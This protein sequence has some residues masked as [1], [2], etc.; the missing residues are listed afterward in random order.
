MKHERWARKCIQG[1]GGEPERKYHLETLDV[2]G[3]EILQLIF[4]SL[5]V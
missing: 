4:L 5:S 3:R 1:F 2:H